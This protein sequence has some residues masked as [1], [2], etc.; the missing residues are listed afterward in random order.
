MI[1]ID[2]EFKC[3]MDEV[4]DEMDLKMNYTNKG[5]DVPKSERK[6]QTMKHRIHIKY[7]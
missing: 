1:H 3:I 5:E 6:N 2:R 7:H 4:E